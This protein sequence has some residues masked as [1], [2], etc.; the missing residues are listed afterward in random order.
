VT[1]HPLV[2]LLE[3]VKRHHLAGQEHD[4]QLEQWEL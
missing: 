1:D 2:P 4:G 3:D